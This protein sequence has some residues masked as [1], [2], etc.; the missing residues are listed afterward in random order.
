MIL[1]AQKQGEFADWN[2]HLNYLSHAHKNITG[3]QSSTGTEALCNAVA[4]LAVII[5]LVFIHFILF[6]S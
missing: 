6:F 3:D 5:E 1:N 2:K 4:T